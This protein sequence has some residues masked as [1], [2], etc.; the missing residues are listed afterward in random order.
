MD[1]GPGNGIS[2]A[3]HL[4]EACRVL[5]FADHLGNLPLSLPEIDEF[6][7]TYLMLWQPGTS[8]ISEVVQRAQKNLQTG[9]INADSI[10]KAISHL[11][12]AVY[13]RRLDMWAWEGANR[14]ATQY[15]SSPEFQAD[16]SFSAA[17]AEKLTSIIKDWARQAFARGLT[18]ATAVDVGAAACRAARA[19]YDARP[20]DGPAAQVL[21][22]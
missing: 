13:C 2:R 20:L 16:S 11:R 15:Q 4:P 14:A 8:G 19:S 3:L 21:D 18:T 6:P 9:L 12:E 7:G 17:R 1:M 10:R 5:W 22:A